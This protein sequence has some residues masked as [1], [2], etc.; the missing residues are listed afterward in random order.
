MSLFSNHYGRTGVYGSGA[1]KG[2][3]SDPP[4]SLVGISFSD[5]KKC[6]HFGFD[7]QQGLGWDEVSGDRWVWPETQ[8]AVLNV[9]DDIGQMLLVV[10]DEASGLPFVISTKDGPSGSGMDRTYVDKYDPYHPQNPIGY[11]DIESTIKLPEHF[12]EKKHY[13]IEH[14]ETDLHI[15]PSKASNRGADGYGDNGLLEDFELGMSI[16]VD[17]K[18]VADDTI[19]DVATDAENAFTVKASGPTN[20]I[21]VTT[22]KSDFRLMA[23]ESYYNVKDNAKRPVVGRTTEDDYQKE[24]SLPSVWLSRG[25]NLLLNRANG[26]TLTGTGHSGPGPDG[27]SN[28][29]LVLDSTLYLANAAIADGTFMLWHRAGVSLPVAVTTYDSIGTWYLSYYRGVIGAAQILTIP[30]QIFDLRIYDTE[31]SLAAIAHYFNNIE[32]DEGRLY[33]PVW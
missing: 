7:A 9:F 29:A 1:Y 25:S 18:A 23:V 31:I 5:K 19:A 22:N 14:S 32:N 30:N 16:Y 6:F 4:N 28:T 21:E 12:G 8:G 26:Q 20:Q 13:N 33:L 27:R 10:W 3:I 2:R 24:F 11:S 15:R 17:G